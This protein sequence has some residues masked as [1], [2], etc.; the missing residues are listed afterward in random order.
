M[1]FMF[2]KIETK[3]DFKFLIYAD[4]HYD[5]LA[6]QCVTFDDCAEVE[7]A[8]HDR[9]VDGGFNFSVFLG[10]RFLKR[11]PEDE[12]KTRAD[13]VLM[14]ALHNVRRPQSCKHFSLIGNHDWVTNSRRWHT[15]ESLRLL[16][17][18]GRLEVMDQARTY[19]VPNP[20]VL[21]HALPAGLAFDFSKY[22]IN[23]NC[24]N[25]FV[26]HDM[27]KGSFMDD[28]YTMKF[29][30][31]IN[32]TDIDRPEFDMVM[33]GDIHVPQKFPLHN[34]QGGYAGAVL[35]R[36]KA[37]ADRERGWVEVSV[38]GEPG[39]FSISTEF[40]PTSQLFSCFVFE[41]G[42]QT[43]FDNLKIPDGAVD[44][45]RIEV[46]LVGRKE[47]VDRVSEDPRWANYTDLLRARKL[48]LAR[49][50]VSETKNA[51]VDLSTS[52]SVTNDLA[53]YLDSGFGSLGALS[54]EKMFETLAQVEGE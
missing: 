47:D 20:P 27:L 17:R 37:D 25:L 42:P 31:G 1:V 18:D 51:V 45:K 13:R 49:D 26:F 46:K 24:F 54:R 44:G 2:E 36:T 30:S 3:M 53:L 48:D 33:A 39:N 41:V 8:V 9:V 22:E 4:I 7:K 52:N 15:S 12:I 10:D 5:R 40:H 38:S 14:E 6:A 19:V 21:I 28:T 43:Q 11:N 29:D 34:T 32:I 16:D 35:Q 50:Y 23:P